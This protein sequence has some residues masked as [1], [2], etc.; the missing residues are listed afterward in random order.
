MVL[1]PAMESAAR[2]PSPTKKYYIKPPPTLS[3]AGLHASPRPSSRA[4]VSSRPSTPAK[5]KTAAVSSNCAPAAL[6]NTAI[7]KPSTVSKPVG[8]SSHTTSASVPAALRVPE[9]FQSPKLSPTPTHLLSRPRSQLRRPASVAVLRDDSNSAGS[10]HLGLRPVSSLDVMSSSQLLLRQTATSHGRTASISSRFSTDSLV[11]QGNVRVL[12]R[13]RPFLQRE[14][15]S[16]CKCLLSMDSALGTTTLFHPDDIDRTDDGSSDFGLPLSRRIK[17]AREFVFDESMWSVDSTTKNTQFV[18]QP[19]LYNKVGREFLD[20]SFEGYHTCILAY[21]QT[22]AGKSYTMIGTEDEP[23]LI[24][25][26]CYDLF[27]RIEKMTTATTTF[28]VKI[29]YFEIYNEHVYDLLLPVITEPP[30]P[31][32]VRESPVDGPYV[33]DLTTHSVRTYTEVEKYLKRGNRQRATAATNMNATSSR[34]HAVFTLALKKIQSDPI[35]DETTEET[36]SRIRFVDLAGS[37]RAN[38]TGTTGTRLREGANINKSLTTLGRVISILAE[39]SLASKKRDVVPYR[40]STLTWLLKDN[41]GGNSKT[42]MI[43]CISPCDYEEGLS[44]LRY[45]SQAKHIR[46]RAVVNQDFISPAER[47]QKLVEMQETINKLQD[48]L[49]QYSSTQK[50]QTDAQILELE[51][52]RK[53]IRYYEDKAEVEEAKRRAVMQENETVKLHNRLIT[54]HVKEMRSEAIESIKIPDIFAKEWNSIMQETARF[55]MELSADVLRLLPKDRQVSIPRT[56][57]QVQ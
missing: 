42:A 8:S 10:A 13:A 4:S 37:E 34:S 32:K 31:L 29:S 47:D 40:D 18:D 30:T 54:E 56:T 27:Q 24:P 12:V 16:Q 51:K 15:E 41:L 11:G 20:H 9:R 1:L 57:V 3:T 39:S 14:I 45:A 22:G 38:S 53:V 2:S 33:K 28:T 26:T 36:N 35:M 25:R 7:S 55:R 21:G 46:T 49:A 52:F 19:A 48:T 17:D 50:Q 43:A 6:A 44:T 5:L 23:G